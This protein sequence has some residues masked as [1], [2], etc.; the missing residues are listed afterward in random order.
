MQNQEVFKIRKKFVWIFI[1]TLLLTS[2]LGNISVS[3]PGVLAQ[4]LDQSVNIEEDL[5]KSVSVIEGVYKEPLLICIPEDFIR[6]GESYTIPVFLASENDGIKI[7]SISVV[8]PEIFKYELVTPVQVNIID[9]TSSHMSEKIQIGLD[10]VKEMS[11]IPITVPLGVIGLDKSVVGK[12]T[13]KV[14]IEYSQN[15][16]TAN[17]E[18]DGAVILAA[19]LPSISGYVPGDTHLHSTPNVSGDWNDDGLNK[20][21]TIASNAQQKGLEF[22]WF[23]AHAQMMGNSSNYTR[24]KSEVEAQGTSTFFVSADLELSSRREYDRSDL[25]TQTITASGTKI[26]SWT[27]GNADDGYYAYTLPFSV[28]FYGK[29]YSTIYVSTNGFL[30]FSTAGMTS[31]SSSSIPN[32]NTPNN[33]IAGVWRD[34]NPGSAS[35]TGGV[36]IYPTSTYVDFIYYQVPIYGSTSTVSFSVRLFKNST[37][38]E[39]YYASG[40]PSG[41]VAGVEDSKGEYGRT[42]TVG[43]SYRMSTGKDSHYLAHNLTQYILNPN[44]EGKTGEELINTVNAISGAYG[45]IA[46]PYE[47]Y[48]WLYWTKNTGAGTQTAVTGFQGMELL[49]NLEYI[50]N[51][52]TLTM[53]RQR[54]NSNLQSNITNNRVQPAATSGSDMHSLYVGSWGRH[55]TY[56]Y[57]GTSP[58]TKAN[59]QTAMRNGR[60]IASSDGSLT[61]FYTTVG[62]TQYHVGS[63]VNITSGTSVA[64]QGRAIPASL[65]Y[66]VGIRVYNSSGTL[67]ASPTPDANGNWSYTTPQITGDTWY[68][69]ELLTNDTNS[70]SYTSYTNP[71]ILNVL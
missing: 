16:K 31:N 8:A 20:P 26:T 7:K 25:S 10:T 69:V 12:S 64:F 49:S 2:L 21:S 34:L 41:G 54:L 29:N 46:H 47:G 36:Y 62:G 18:A 11:F 9:N 67:V 71:I 38:V 56:V 42:A 60:T 63:A 57:L 4:K 35:G 17:I 52:N 13:F 68:R 6:G 5:Q 55:M 59:I 45:N 19:P 24:Y 66:I 48:P 28:N 43:T 65:S 27:S 50:A 15:G 40:T 58:K 44:P 70:M 1:C 51:S 14:S 61:S 23:T 53:W 32:V 3:D 39:V 33:M 30:G 22:L 37:D